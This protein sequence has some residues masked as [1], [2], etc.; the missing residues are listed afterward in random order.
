MLPRG[1]QKL[2]TRRGPLGKGVIRETPRGDKAGGRKAGRTPEGPTVW[3]GQKLPA[4]PCR[5]SE[6]GQGLKEPRGGQ[7][8]PA[9]RTAAF[10]ARPR[11]VLSKEPPWRGLAAA[12]TRARPGPWFPETESLV[13]ASQQREKPLQEGQEERERRKASVHRSHGLRGKEQAGRPASCVRS[14]WKRGNSPG[15]R[16]PPRSDAPAV[17]P[18]LPRAAQRQAV[19]GKD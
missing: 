17:R 12:P 18:S 2:T 10:A 5:L 11:L 8:S 1:P 4:R 14:G 15:G 3:A 6:A 9:S 16:P 7:E 19:L 13:A